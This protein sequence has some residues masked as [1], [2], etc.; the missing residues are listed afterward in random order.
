VPLPAAPQLSERCLVDIPP[1]AIIV[2]P[3]RR[4]Q[5]DAVGAP[6]FQPPREASLVRESPGD[7]G[8]PGE[9]REAAG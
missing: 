1:G 6:R 7:R 2:W 4:T 8:D 3:E 9:P 5:R